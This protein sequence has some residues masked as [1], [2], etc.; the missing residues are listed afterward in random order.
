MSMFGLVLIYN[1]F[2]IVAKDEVT[3]LVG[4]IFGTLQRGLLGWIRI[5]ASFIH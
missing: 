1:L 4:G 5:S 2:D 3:K